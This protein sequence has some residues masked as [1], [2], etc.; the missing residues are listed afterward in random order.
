MLDEQTYL[1]QTSFGGMQ[2][3]PS[4]GESI[5]SWNNRVEIISWKALL[6]VSVCW[7]H[8]E[9][10]AWCTNTHTCTHNSCKVFLHPS[11]LCTYL[12]MHLGYIHAC[13]HMTGAVTHTHTKSIHRARAPQSEARLASV[14]QEEQRALIP[15]TAPWCCTLWADAIYYSE[16]GQVYSLKAT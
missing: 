13:I 11:I 3:M 12:C 16:G 2:R 6:P 4:A 1:T 10:L 5:T 8:L 14:T 15:S 9:R 7:V